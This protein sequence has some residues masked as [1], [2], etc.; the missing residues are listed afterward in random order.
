MAGRFISPICLWVSAPVT[1]C[2]S[3]GIFTFC[4]FNNFPRY[5]SKPMNAI[6]IATMNKIS[7]IAFSAL[8][9][10]LAF[11]LSIAAFRPLARSRGLPRAQK[12]IMNNLGESVNI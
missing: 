12:C 8:T 3:H 9:Y 2:S 1:G 10:H 7:L 11:V 6:R 4:D 5:P